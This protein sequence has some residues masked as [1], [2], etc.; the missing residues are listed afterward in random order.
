MKKIWHMLQILIFIGC[1][2]PITELNLPDEN[3]KTQIT[4]N[5]EKTST[6]SFN[7]TTAE[8]WEKQINTA[9]IYVY[10]ASTGKLIYVYPLKS[11][12]IT[13][14]N[15]G[16]SRTISFLLPVIGTQ[17]YNIY[18]IANTTPSASVSTESNLQTSI[19]QDIS[20]YNG[21]YD[22]VTTKAL[23]TNGFVMTGSAPGIALSNGGSSTINITLRRIVAKIGIEINISA[24]LTLGTS[25]VTDVSLTQYATVSNL[26]PLA[27]ANTTGTAATLTQTAKQDASNNRK[28]RAFFYIYENN[29]SAVSTNQVKLTFKVVNTLLVST[30]YTYNAYI[31]SDGT[32]KITRNQGYHIIAN[33]NKLINILFSVRPPSPSLMTVKEQADFQEN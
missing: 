6:R 29:A 4:L 23:R 8:A 32:G 2:S 15:N 24:L 12:E 16:T 7:T 14:I 21:T 27:I 33:V 19:E 1:Q 28:F 10:R 22:N 18:M 26:L 3:D 5:I 20:S 31:T 30:T 25:V 9:N 11:T 13:A 17:N